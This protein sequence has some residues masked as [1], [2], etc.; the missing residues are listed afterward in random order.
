MSI[1]ANP[2]PAD[3]PNSAAREL[4]ALYREGAGEE[5]DA[6]LDRRILDAARNELLADKTQK[7]KPA[8]PWWKTWA[9]PMSTAAVMILGLSLTWTVIDEQERAL[10]DEISSADI[11]P[12]L[13]G[14]TKNSDARAEPATMVQAP[15]RETATNDQTPKAEKKQ[16]IAPPPAAVAEPQAFTERQDKA[17]SVSSAIGSLAKPVA[18]ADAPANV[19]LR[20]AVVAP[21]APPPAIVAPPSPAPAL[22]MPRAEA[23]SD[24]ATKAS[25]KRIASPAMLKE[26]DATDDAAM[27]EAWLD[28]IRKLRAAGRNAEAAQSLERFRKRYP[29]VA[30]PDDLL[31]VKSP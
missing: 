28:Q 13:A 12:K 6:L 3:L 25:A 14:K 16:D 31:E 21:A 1:P 26:A 17:K 5:P 30:L 29:G 22:A 19:E 7:T 15:M 27:P 8:M 20:K 4:H 18:T 2:S 11:P 9:R 10:R 23:M 24:Q